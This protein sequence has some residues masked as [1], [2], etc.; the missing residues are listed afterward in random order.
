LPALR[1]GII[2]HLHGKSTEPN[3]T[4]TAEALNF[5]A[6]DNIPDRPGQELRNLLID[7]FYVDG[8][9]AQTN[10]HLKIALTMTEI[11]LG[12]QTDATSTR[13]QLNMT[14]K[15]TLVDNA[16]KTVLTANWGPAVS[17]DPYIKFS[18]Q[19][20]A[21][22]DELKVTWVDNLGKTDTVAAKIA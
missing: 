17:K 9:P 21:K 4:S 5:V 7:R 15:Y 19:G 11:Q 18:F 6:I 10:Y 3:G 2:A 8:R 12:I 14:A 16:G 1:V 20:G 22:G 13:S